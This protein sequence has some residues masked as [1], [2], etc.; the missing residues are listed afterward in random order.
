M[1]ENFLSQNKGPVGE[2]SNFGKMNR[3][4]VGLVFTTRFSDIFFDPYFHF[5][6]FRPFFK[7]KVFKAF[8]LLKISSLENFGT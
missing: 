8:Y 7:F 6:N 2:K 1:E 5:E 4:V 3:Y